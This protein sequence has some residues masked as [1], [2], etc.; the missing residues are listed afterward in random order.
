MKDLFA[1]NHESAAQC[2]AVYDSYG[3]R[4]THRPRITKSNKEKRQEIKSH[5]LRLTL[6]SRCTHTHR[7]TE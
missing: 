5:I 7:G 2:R 6:T 4:L 3:N 1:A